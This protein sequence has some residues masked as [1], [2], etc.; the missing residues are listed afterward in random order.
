MINNLMF[1]PE[2]LEEFVISTNQNRCLHG[3]KE[4]GIFLQETFSTSDVFDSWKYDCSGDMNLSH[5]SNHG[6]GVLVLIRETLQF[7]LKSVR[8]DI[9]GRFVIV[10]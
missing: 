6:K 1:D 3:E 2:M 9:H 8:K 4:Q 5:A 10:E 7:E